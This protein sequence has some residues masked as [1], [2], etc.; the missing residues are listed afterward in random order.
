MRSILCYESYDSLFVG[1]HDR[2]EIQ[3][4]GSGFASQISPMKFFDL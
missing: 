1:I 2:N 3:K 4:D